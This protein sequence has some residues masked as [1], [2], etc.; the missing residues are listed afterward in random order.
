[1]IPRRRLPITEPVRKQPAAKR[2]AH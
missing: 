1:L 2:A